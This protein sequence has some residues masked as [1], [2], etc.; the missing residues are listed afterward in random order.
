MKDIHLYYRS[1]YSDYL[2]KICGCV[3]NT[4]SSF[5]NLNFFQKKV[6]ETTSSRPRVFAPT[7]VPRVPVAVIHVQLFNVEAAP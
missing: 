6:R 2:E 3:Y 1:A 5:C 4:K 7:V